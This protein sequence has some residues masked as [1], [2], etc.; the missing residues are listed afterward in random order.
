M[1][2]VMH[3]FLECY[4]RGQ[5]LSKISANTGIPEEEILHML[6]EYKESQRVGRHYTEEFMQLIARRDMRG[7]KRSEIMNELGISRNLLIRS[8]EE[9]GIIVNTEDD[10]EELFMTVDDDFEFES[11]PI[12]HSKRI[13][14]VQGICY[15]VLTEKSIYCMNCGNEFSHI[16]NEVYIVK[17]E[18]ID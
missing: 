14:E 6:K 5:P 18:Y 7:V 8:V 17:W 9:F 12:C 4:G 16:E 3:E 15:D 13:N 1:T 10:S 11:C 2:E